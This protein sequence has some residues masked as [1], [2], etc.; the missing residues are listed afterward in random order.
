MLGENLLAFAQ[1][2]NF[3]RRR[4]ERIAKEKQEER[5]F[6]LDMIDTALDKVVELAKVQRDQSIAQSQSTAELAGVFKT[7][8][9]MFKAANDS[10]DPPSTVRAID[11]YDDEM[12]RERERLKK[13]G[14]PVDAPAN[15]QLAWLIDNPE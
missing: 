1:W 10:T 3:P 2:L 4:R 7:Y 13:R 14:F 11:E 8:L 5:E 15:E 12:R 9:E 6:M